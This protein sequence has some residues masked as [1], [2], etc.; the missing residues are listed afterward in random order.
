LEK[1]VDVVGQMIL[2]T[3]PIIVTPLYAFYRVKKFGKGI[4]VILAIFAIDT[5]VLIGT[6]ERTNWVNMLFVE[7][8]FAAPELSYGYAVTL[9]IDILLPMYFARKWTIEYNESIGTGV[10]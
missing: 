2:A 9:I 7:E 4:L 3:I 8:I 10:M 5:L 6:G 1:K